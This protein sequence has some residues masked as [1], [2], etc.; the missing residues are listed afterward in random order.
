M[1]LGKSLINLTGRLKDKSRKNRYKLEH[2]KHK[3]CGDRVKM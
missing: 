3:T 2:R 1:E